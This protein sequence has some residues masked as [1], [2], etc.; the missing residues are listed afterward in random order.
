M[1]PVL[2]YLAHPVGAPD[3][4][5]VEAHLAAFR[6]WLT[7]LVELPDD[8]C[9]RI[10]WCAPWVPYAQALP[11]DQPQYRAR[12][13]RDTLAA[14]ERCDALVALARTT[15]GVAREF[16]H[17][18]ACGLP[19]A[20]YVV[21]CKNAQAADGNP[22]TADKPFKTISAANLELIV[23]KINDFLLASADAQFKRQTIVKFYQLIEQK[24]PGVRWYLAKSLQVL[25][26]GSAHVDPLLTNSMINN[27][28]DIETDAPVGKKTLA[29]RVGKN[30]AKSIYLVMIWAPLAIN[31]T[32]LKINLIPAFAFSFALVLLLLPLTLIVL[33]A[34]TPKENILA[35]KL[36]SNAALIYAILVAL[37]LWKLV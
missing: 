5:G 19:A 36:T 20:E 16:E 1:R 34:R 14:L 2:V 24:A 15:P 8:A 30:F 21:D 37:G 23:A 6:R 28:R 33:T 12:G 35:L 32:Y 13:M 22:G 3:R 25:Q 10:A 7:Y 26:N 4:A 11:D 27:I 18:A 9:R 31:W 17:A 29:V